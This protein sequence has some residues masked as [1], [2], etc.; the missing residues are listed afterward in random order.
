M[1]SCE[2]RCIPAR[3]ASQHDTEF[4]NVQICSCRF[5]KFVAKSHINWR[6]VANSPHQGEIV[7]SAQYPTGDETSRSVTDAGDLSGALPSQN[8][9]HTRVSK[10]CLGPLQVVVR[11]ASPSVG[12]RRWTSRRWLWRSGC[13]VSRATVYRA[14]GGDDAMATSAAH[15]ARRENSRVVVR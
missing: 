15:C 3:K 10:V 4:K 7:G 14:L 13:G 1:T 11:E 6:M 5:S 12:P 8:R 9:R 2:T